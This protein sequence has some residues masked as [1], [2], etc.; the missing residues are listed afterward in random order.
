MPAATALSEEHVLEA[1]DQLQAVR[2]TSYVHL[3]SIRTY[4]RY[5][6]QE[7]TENPAPL[8]PGWG[9]QVFKRLQ[10]MRDQGK[11]EQC[12]QGLY[13]RLSPR[14]K[15]LLRTERARLAR[16]QLRPKPTRS[17]PRTPGWPTPSTPTA[18]HRVTQAAGPPAT[19]SPL[20]NA[21]PDT[22]T[23]KGALHRLA[24]QRITQLTSPRATQSS[25]WL[26]TP[27]P[28]VPP[29]TALEDPTT[30]L[31]QFLFGKRPRLRRVT[32]DPTTPRDTPQRFVQEQL[33]ER[34][35][36]KRRL[37]LQEKE[38]LER[39]ARRNIEQLQATV[40]AEKTDHIH[41]QAQLMQQVVRLQRQL[42][43]LNTKLQVTE[44]V[45]GTRLRTQEEEKAELERLLRRATFSHSPCTLPSDPLS[46]MDW[47]PASPLQPMLTTP[48][49]TQGRPLQHSLALSADG[50]SFAFDDLE[51][52]FM[53]LRSQPTD[54]MSS[55]PPH[56]VLPDAMDTD[57]RED[58]AVLPA[59]PDDCTLQV[60]RGQ[61]LLVT[62]APSAIEPQRAE[63]RGPVSREQT[64]VI[65]R[66]ISAIHDEAERVRADMASQGQAALVEMHQAYLK[67]LA[68]TESLVHALASDTA[69]GD[70][71]GLFQE[72]RGSFLSKMADS[73]AHLAGER[74]AAVTA[75]QASVPSSVPAPARFMAVEAEGLVQATQP[76][77][78]LRKVW[79]I[80]TANGALIDQDQQPRTNDESTKVQPTPPL[81]DAERWSLCLQAIETMLKMR[82]LAEQRVQT[83]VQRLDAAQ[84]TEAKLQGAVDA[85]TQAMTQVQADHAQAMAA[86]AQDHH[87]ALDRTQ[88]NHTRR[89]AELETERAQEARA[90]QS[91]KEHRDTLQREIVATCCD[92]E[93][94]LEGLRDELD[95]V[96][97]QAQR[98]RD[99]AAADRSALAMDL[100]V[101]R[102]ET[103]ALRDK[104]S[105]AK[106]LLAQRTEAL[107]E[108]TSRTQALI[109][110]IAQR[111]HRHAEACADLQA[112]LDRRDTHIT[113]LEE[114]LASL[115]QQLV[116]T[117]EAA[118]ADQDHEC[119]RL[120]HQIASLQAELVQLGQEKVG[121]VEQYQ[122]RLDSLH[123][124]L[125]AAQAKELSQA[126]ELDSVRGAMAELRRQ[127]DDTTN[128]LHEREQQFATQMA[129]LDGQV[130]DALSRKRAL[131][132]QA[133]PSDSDEA[134][135][136]DYVAQLQGIARELETLDTQRQILHSAYRADEELWHS[137]R[138]ELVDEL[139][140][141]RCQ[142]RHLACERAVDQVIASPV[143]DDS[144]TPAIQPLR[145]ALVTTQQAMRRIQQP[146]RQARAELGAL[147][148]QRHHQL[149][150]WNEQQARLVATREELQ[151]Q[152]ALNQHEADALPGPAPHPDAPASDDHRATLAQLDDELAGQLH[153]LHQDGKQQRAGHQAQLADIDAQIAELH[154]TIATLLESHAHLE[155][156][157]QT[158]DA[159]LQSL[160]AERRGCH[161]S[162]THEASDAEIRELYETVETLA[163][164]CETL[165]GQVQR[166][167]GLLRSLEGDYVQVE[168]QLHE[169]Q[170]ALDG[171]IQAH[172]RQ[173][174]T[175]R[176][177]WTACERALQDQVAA[178]KHELAEAQSA[179]ETHQAQASDQA[180]RQIDGR[181]VL[182]QKLSL[183]TQECT[184][185]SAQLT[186]EQSCVTDLEASIETLRQNLADAETQAATHH[187]DMAHAQH[188]LRAQLTEAHAA[189]AV[190]DED[191]TVL[192]RAL[193]DAE[194][195]H[196]ILQQQA[197]CTATALRDMLEHMQ[198]ELTQA[199]G[200]L[201]DSEQARQH[202]LHTIHQQSQSL[203]QQT[204]TQQMVRDQAQKAQQWLNQTLMTQ[205]NQ[206]WTNV[207]RALGDEPVELPAKHGSYQGIPR[208]EGQALPGELTLSH[209]VAS[210]P[211]P[212]PSPSS[213]APSTQGHV[214]L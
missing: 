170:Q 116:T 131:L 47:T 51:D 204:A 187:A 71:Q 75:W 152:L 172:H 45:Q 64:Q 151:T 136:K 109:D 108:A 48:P 156:Q 174:V 9:K 196:D 30:P 161:P 97:A 180:Q 214:G 121:L 96:R 206:M 79:S 128:Q 25:A 85:H 153:Q 59:G 185:L 123:T 34:A 21:S 179:Y 33:V 132:A 38:R 110:D 100:D 107:S 70:S 57:G 60:P 4:V 183:L 69:L 103:V 188:Q 168:T 203:Q 99:Q 90:H 101:S 81:P 1:I 150:A 27:P 3:N 105:E 22:S 87:A 20:T 76:R 42:N 200:Q 164:R 73:F 113:S 106:A 125:Q 58:E 143:E 39:F 211:S 62:P 194:A 77:R 112:T 14:L 163:A 118:E 181:L 16:H 189:Q 63:N 6:L 124:E 104:L 44:R 83:L 55:P 2:H 95:R 202:L 159:E 11:V 78:I 160:V 61:S 46:A 173:L 157:W 175:H 119:T 154:C 166:C 13:F 15:R 17:S 84:V 120:R 12:N 68:V 65:D 41:Q 67:H 93:S 127:L 198:Q 193:A 178:L 148:T 142:L 167:T 195:Q 126:H 158:N 133:S 191:M 92:Y 10:A 205:M 54:P 28:P 24:Y 98:D 43:H 182:E 209:P 129:S 50:L 144:L 94:Q 176:E 210:C 162:A 86:V 49:T 111:E 53:H 138:D 5:R 199:R 23:P 147:E 114:Q 37:A 137:E 8:T 82:Q 80:L 169:T 72:D 26:A 29:P 212:C 7:E 149:Q 141:L 115:T 177:S 135:P 146:L 117:T 102:D 52:T 155:Q 56:Q 31:H 40:R 66:F 140:L 35:E 91:V 32:L 192:Q 186:T 207:Q 145:R 139:R 134:A 190:A 184:Q 165:E 18:A 19:P 36:R 201:A 171:T 88:H 74:Q 130:A 208:S 213:L 122:A 89:L 197:C